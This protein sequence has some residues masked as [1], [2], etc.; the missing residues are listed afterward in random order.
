[1]RHRLHTFKIGRTGAHRKAMLANMVSS[2]IE[3]GQIKTTI[4]KAKEARRFAEKM[5]TLGKK[6]DL[7]RRRL[8]ISKLRNTDAVKKLFDEIAPQY[9]EREGGYTR[10]I[11][12]G[13][14]VGD[15]AEMCILQFVES[16]APAKKQKA[17]PAVKAEE[18]AE[19]PAEE[20][21]AEETAEVAE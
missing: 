11:K 19:A 8:A 12:L 20:A 18:K 16:G 1:M 10:I 14:R 4:T 6:G 13:Q 2:L 15:G 17:A 21:K 9:A 5:V 3:H 7:H